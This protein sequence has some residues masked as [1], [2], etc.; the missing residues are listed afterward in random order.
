MRMKRA[1]VFLLIFSIF[2]IPLNDVFAEL[3]IPNWFR[4]NA[5]WWAEDKI[6]D[7]D[8][9]KGLEYLIKKEIIKI[10][11]S[12]SPST[13]SEQKIPGWIKNNADWWSENLISDEEFV[14]SIQYLINV[15]IIQLPPKDEKVSFSG[16]SPLFT[17]YAFKQDF[18]MLEGQKI[19]LE[20]FFE[21]KSGLENVYQEITLFDSSQRAA[22]IKPI[23]TSTAYWEPGFYTYY[24]GECDEKCLTKPIEYDKPLGF[25]ASDQGFKVFALLGY[26]VLTDVDVDKDSD[27]LK[28]YDKVVVLHNEYVTKREFNA[29]V[30]HPKVVYLYP[31]ALYAEISTD[32]K[33]NTI[34][35][36]KGHGFPSSDIGNGF[37]WEF[38]NSHPY[39]YDT[40]CENWEFVEIDNGIMLNCYPE[41]IIYIDKELLK[42]IK[43][44]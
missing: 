4:N 11:S 10:P 32:Y 19:S 36:I 12:V 5:K 2:L 22:V 34:T 28:K 18:R 29:I 15:G 26:E 43:N 40:E 42:A 31:N 35:L 1:L 37:D 39:E 41:N 20:S 6:S 30:D 25:S 38:D 16:Y 17:K 9:S 23:F 8:F 21:F 13:Y 27:L 3:E 7:N 33:N 14:S 24:R 44:Y